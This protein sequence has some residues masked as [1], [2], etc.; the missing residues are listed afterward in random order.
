MDKINDAKLERLLSTA[1]R[2]PPTEEHQGWMNEQIK[3]TLSKKTRGELTYTPL[4]EARR[5][6][7]LDAS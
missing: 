5:E 7:G 3:T 4:D 6:F 2:H 1:E